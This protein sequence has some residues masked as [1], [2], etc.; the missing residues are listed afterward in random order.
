M[1]KDERKEGIKIGEKRGEK[2]GKIETA[3]KMIKKG[4]ETDIIMELTGLKKEEV[5]PA[6]LTS[7]LLQCQI[8]PCLL[9]HA[10]SPASPLQCTV[11]YASSGFSRLREA[12]ASTG[13]FS[14][15]QQFLVGN[16]G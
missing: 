14:I 16:A 3:K 10:P 13:I 1:A 12:F 5:Y 9:R 7:N 6:F 4:F 8:C 2:R 11:K 15:S